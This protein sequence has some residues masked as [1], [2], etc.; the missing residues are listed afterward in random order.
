M[1]DKG[2]EDSLRQ[3]FTDHG[4]LIVVRDQQLEAPP[5]LCR[6]VALFGALERNDKYDPDFLLPRSLKF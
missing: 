1:L 5:D 2:G 6:F 3:A 4:G